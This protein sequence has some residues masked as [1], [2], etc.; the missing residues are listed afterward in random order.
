MK[1]NRE[2]EV[3]HYQVFISYRRGDAAETARAIQLA[4][5]EKAIASFLDVD[6]LKS[7]YFDE[8]LL[9][10]IKKTPNFLLILT[11]GCLDKCSDKDDWLRKE[12][13]C[14]IENDRNIIPIFKDNFQFPNVEELPECEDLLNRLPRH[15]GIKYDHDY[16]PAVI[17]KIIEFI[18]F[19]NDHVDPPPPPDAEPKQYNISIK[20]FKDNEPST[21]TD[22]KLCYTYSDKRDRE[23]KVFE[24]TVLPTTTFWGQLY[25]PFHL[26]KKMTN[27]EL[28]I[29]RDDLT[30][31]KISSIRKHKKKY[32]VDMHSG[33]SINVYLLESQ[34]MGVWY[35]S[36]QKMRFEGI[37]DRFGQKISIPIQN[38]ESLEFTQ[39][40]SASDTFPI[41][42]GQPGGPFVVKQSEKVS[43]DLIKQGYSEFVED[44]EREFV[45]DQLVSF[46]QFSY[47][48]GAFYATPFTIS[49]REIEQFDFSKLRHVVCSR[50][51]A[52][53]TLKIG[54]REFEERIPHDKGIIGQCKLGVVYI[55]LGHP[56][57]I[58]A[59]F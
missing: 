6:D 10:V 18:K 7:H 15:N 25:I 17:S 39:S 53:M 19:D 22:V 33:E 50:R 23:T 27:L 49:G 14:A 34:H 42:E 59:L 36:N 3:M 12:I 51:E 29:T 1:T 4:L 21:L 57:E 55:L 56:L 40:G 5:Q 13:L 45:I 28:D 44:V 46:G 16:F 8:N 2:I 35:R 47:G 58:K 54:N 31:E 38:I 11:P 30:P 43:A 48:G 26:I 52:K 32:Q 37:D 24:K 9:K 20:T 41:P